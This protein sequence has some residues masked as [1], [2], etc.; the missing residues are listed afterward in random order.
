MTGYQD[1]SDFER[2]VIVRKREMGHSISEVA[3]EFVFL[4]TAISRVYH[5]YQVSG[6]TSNLQL[7]CCRKKTLKE[8]DHRRLARILKRRRRATLP[9]IATDFNAE[10]STTFS[11]RTVQRTII[12]MSFRSRRP[13]RFPLL[14][15]R[16]KALYLAWVC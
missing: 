1:L 6:R 9:Q 16:H 3:M 12:D 5:E 4:C 11:L 15:A 14:T 2:G 10:A 7:W 13:T 8:R